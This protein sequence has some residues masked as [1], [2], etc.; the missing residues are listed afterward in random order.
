MVRAKRLKLAVQWKL[1]L[2][3]YAEADKQRAEADKQYAEADKLWAEADKQRAEADKQYAEA[4]KLWA[5]SVIAAYGNIRL[6]WIYRDGNHDCK[7]E[8]GDLYR[9]G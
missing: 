5:E 1:C 9:H 4:D 8:N 6:E 7:L 2:K 3:Q